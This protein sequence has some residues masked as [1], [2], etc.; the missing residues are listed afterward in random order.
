LVVLGACYGSLL[1]KN[2]YL[3]YVPCSVLIASSEEIDGNSL[4]DRLV[5]FY[6]ALFCSGK[7]SVAMA[8]INDP[9]FEG[10]GEFSLFLPSENAEA[11]PNGTDNSGAAPLR[12]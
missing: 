8:R 5:E 10:D 7:T 12:V 4:S 6:T 9:K 3:R 2:E 11:Q 1:F